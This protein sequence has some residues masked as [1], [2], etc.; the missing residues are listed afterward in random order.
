M[1]FFVSGRLDLTT[2]MWEC[3]YIC[4]ENLRDDPRG[5]YR[6][7][8]AYDDDYVYILGG[9]TQDQSFDL[10][11]LPAYSLNDNKWSFV[12][13]LPDPNTEANSG[14]PE[15]RRFHSC[16]QQQTVQGM[17]AIIAG[18][19]RTQEKR[20]DD[21]WK[22]NLKTFQWKRFTQTKL[23]YTL[24]FHDAAATEN[25]QMYVFGGVT[26]INSDLRTNEVHRMWTKI[27]KLTEMCWEAVL[28]Y[29]PGLMYKTLMELLT[30]GI[31]RHYA[32]RIGRGQNC[33]VTFNDL[34]INPVA[35]V[36]T[37]EAGQ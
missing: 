28:H 16:I 10:E 24:Y 23:P 3:C 34:L 27:P 8:V 2:L 29:N 11:V 12:K 4:N 22:L 35:N 13:T 21:I 37:T 30:L 25:G 7:E 5:R 15:P 19:Y 36:D 33:D 6:H 18:G 32:Q 9:G 26:G 20:F 1:F 17:E 14:Y 31:P